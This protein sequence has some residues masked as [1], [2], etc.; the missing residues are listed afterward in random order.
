M[1]LPGRRTSVY[2]ALT[3]GSGGLVFGVGDMAIHAE[4][5]PEVIEENRDLI[6][7][8]DAGMLVFDGNL[9]GDTCLTHPL[10]MYVTVAVTQPITGLPVYNETLGTAEESLQGGAAYQLQGFKDEIF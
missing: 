10:A 1:V 6:L 9:R 5:T 3:D 8:P 4:V 2:N 7:G